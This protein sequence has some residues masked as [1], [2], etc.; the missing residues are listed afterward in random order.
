MA[1]LWG[2]PVN[3][4]VCCSKLAGNVPSSLFISTSSGLI[5]GIYSLSSYFNGD[6]IVTESLGKFNNVL[7]ETRQYF[8][9]GMFNF[10]LLALWF[11]TKTMP[12]F[13]WRY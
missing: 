3:K 1:L 6:A 4:R 13:L 8:M 2:N 10:Q 12:C 7:E 11:F 5:K 9:V